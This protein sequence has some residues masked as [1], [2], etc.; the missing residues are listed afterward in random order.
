MRKRLLII[1]VALNWGSTGHI[2]EHIGLLAIE[3]GWEVYMAHGARYINQSAL[4]SYQVES[5][6]GEMFHYLGSSLCDAQ[7]LGSRTATIRFIKYIDSI[8]PDVIHLHNIHGCF[9]N[10]PLL[11]EHLHKN[12]IPVI[13]TLHDCWS[14]T[15]HCT[16]FERNGCEKWMTGCYDCPSS[17]DFPKSWFYDGSKRNYELKKKCFLGLDRVVLVPVSEWL[18]GLVKK[19][20]MGVYPIHVIT[21]GVDVSVFKE[22]KNDIRERLGIK[23]NYMLL[24][25]AQGFDDR[26]GVRDYAQLSLMLSDDYQLVL[27]GATEEDKKV[28][29][30]NI[31]A[32]GPTN[33]VKEL[34][35]FYSAADILLSLSY[36]ETF[37][38][39]IA[40]GMAC[41]TPA[42]I[43][44]NTGQAEI[45]TPETGFKVTTGD[46]D[47]IKAAIEKV[48]SKGRFSYSQACRYRVEKCFNKDDRYEKYVRMY[49]KMVEQ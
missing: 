40:E 44:D 48:C 39:T 10:F 2:A 5:K 31:L 6:V 37:G 35:E 42:V 34:V 29:P 13:W 41:G 16:Y 15:G 1:N 9:L 3:E 49:D 19:S 20:F 24:A 23:A 46:I 43:Y 25:V 32:L 17:K 8:K 12:Q 45:V 11:F 30:K 38:L 4:Q 22:V 47:S 36:E 21:N 26:K 7:G 27:V 14:F 18:G 28:L 33:G